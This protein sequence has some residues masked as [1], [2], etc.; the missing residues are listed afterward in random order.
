MSWRERAT[1]WLGVRWGG[2]APQAEEME[3]HSAE[4]V[5]GF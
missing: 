2:L 3:L 1:G 4:T 5:E